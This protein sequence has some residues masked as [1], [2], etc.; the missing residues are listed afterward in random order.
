M[1]TQAMA[2]ATYKP[3][4]IPAM[5]GSM[6]NVGRLGGGFHYSQTQPPPASPK[7]RP[8]SP[9]GKAAG[10]QPLEK[11]PRLIRPESAPAAYYSSTVGGFDQSRVN[12]D[13]YRCAAGCSCWHGTREGVERARLQCMGGSLGAGIVGFPFT[14]SQEKLG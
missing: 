2:P 13:Q 8:S 1:K 5:A 10:S 7:L 3:G 9:S 6:P 11:P 4:V 14:P 12:S